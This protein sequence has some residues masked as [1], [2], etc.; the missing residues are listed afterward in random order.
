M[1]ERLRGQDLKRSWEWLAFAGDLPAKP[2]RINNLSGNAELY[3]GRCI[4]TGMSF[5]YTG[6]SG[7]LVTLHD[8]QDTSG[9]PVLFGGFGSNQEINKPVSGKGVLCEI[10]VFAEITTGPVNGVVWFIPLAHYNITPP[11]T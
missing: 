11:G 3:T 8:G 4:V 2:L 10:G 6:T 7:G 9:A 1:S 5:V